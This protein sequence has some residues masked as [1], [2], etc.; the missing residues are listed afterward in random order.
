MRIILLLSGLA[1]SLAGCGGGGNR[2]AGNAGA[3]DDGRAAAQ[4]M[5]NRAMAQTQQETLETRVTAL[6]HD[7][8]RLKAEVETQQGLDAAQRAGGGSVAGASSPL[9]PPSPPLPAIAPP[10]TSAPAPTNAQN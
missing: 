6:E 2:A 5:A 7:V 10:P 1:L 8:D 4:D 3:T 9:V